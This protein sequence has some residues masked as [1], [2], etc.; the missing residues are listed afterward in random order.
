MTWRAA[1]QRGPKSGRV[2]RLTARPCMAAALITAA[3]T[4]IGCGPWRMGLS[5]RSWTA[6]RQGGWQ[7]SRGPANDRAVSFAAHT[8]HHCRRRPSPR[9][10]PGGQRWGE[11]EAGS[12]VSL[13]HWRMLMLAC[14]PTTARPSPPLPAKPAL[15]C[16]PVPMAHAGCS[17]PAHPIL[18]T[19]LPLLPLLPLPRPPSSC[20]A[21]PAEWSVVV[22]ELATANRC[23][24]LAYASPGLQRARNQRPR[25]RG[26][27]QREREGEG[28]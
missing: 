6:R 26:E 25:L 15:G 8:N 23:R 24:T 20:L 10:Q 1:G 22:V 27:Q 16:S 18:P 7:G 5:R 17:V 4:R 19:S 12:R 13:A 9:L 21:K 28:G 2:A 3:W 11:S 14:R